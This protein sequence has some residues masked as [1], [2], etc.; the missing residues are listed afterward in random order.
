M[1]IRKSRSRSD[2]WN[3]TKSRPTTQLIP[4]LYP[5]RGCLGVQVGNILGINPP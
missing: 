1:G 4:G 3:T 5:A 2:S